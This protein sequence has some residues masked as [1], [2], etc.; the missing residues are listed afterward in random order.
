MGG[1]NWNPMS[2][3]PRT[4]L[5]YLPTLRAANFMLDTV[6]GHEY[7]P[8]RLNM[9][10]TAMFVSGLQLGSPNLT[11]ALMRQLDELARKYPDLRMR[12]ALTAWDPIAQK[13]VGIRDT[14]LVGPRRRTLTKVTSCSRAPTA[15]CCARLTR[16]TASCS[17]Q[18]DTGSRS[19]PRR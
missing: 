6:K 10:I 13:A 3:N 2:Y 15:D 14:G 16:M 17:K 9:G 4:G 8:G 5:V 1:H 18:I 7:H 12:A 11:P 19:S